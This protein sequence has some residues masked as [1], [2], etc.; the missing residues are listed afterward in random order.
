ME[1]YNLAFY[2]CFYGTNNNAA[3]KIPEIPSLKYKCYYY[4][5]NSS[6]LENIKDT[7]WIGIYN[8]KPINEDVIKSCMDGKHVKTMPQEYTHLKQYDYLCYLDSKLEKVSEVFVENFIDKYFIE[9]NYA[10]LLRRHWYIPNKVWDEYNESMNQERY[11]LECDKYSKY[12][13]NQLNQGLSDTVQYHSA[14]GFLIR[15]MKHGE[16]NNI[17][18]TWYAHIQEC[19]IQD[20]ISFFFVKQLFNDFIHPFSEIPFVQM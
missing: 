20:Q 13:E 2:T 14:C 16:I 11:R 17:N 12:I 15:N 7:K 5:N 19:G 4:T 1:G 3:F 10:L 8:N 6:I 9:Q 18:T